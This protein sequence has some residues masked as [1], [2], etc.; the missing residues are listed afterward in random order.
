MLA[1]VMTS[2]EPAFVALK[3]PAI[4]VV[5]LQLEIAW[6]W[7]IAHIRGLVFE[8]A[9]IYAGNPTHLC[10]SLGR[11]ARKMLGKSFFITTY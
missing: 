9:S 11:S 6:V 3:Y 1:K 8:M 10:I 2:G 7:D 4:D 5:L